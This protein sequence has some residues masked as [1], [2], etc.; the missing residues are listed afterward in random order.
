MGTSLLMLFWGAMA[1][2]LVTVILFLSV[3]RTK[4]LLLTPCVGLTLGFAWFALC[5]SYFA[6]PEVSLGV[7]IRVD[8]VL[9]P[10]LMVFAAFAVIVRLTQAGRK[11]SEGKT[12]PRAEPGY[13]VP[14]P[15]DG[16]AGDE[17]NAQGRQSGPI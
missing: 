15:V 2:N 17:G 11:I 10:P 5:R 7:P 13:G 8:L 14:P 12:C 4:W 3:R 6:Q 16:S 1:V 9:L